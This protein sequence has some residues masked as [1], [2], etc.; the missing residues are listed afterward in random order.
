MSGLIDRTLAE[1]AF[2]VIH[3][4]I[5]SGELGPGDSLRI[6][7]LAE[8]LQISPTPIREALHRL[9]AIGLAEYVPHRG[10]R[11]TDLNLADLQDL[12]EA[13]LVIEPLAVAKAA[14]KF[15]K[16][17]AESARICLAQMALAQKNEDHTEI[18]KAHSE[19]HFTLYRASQSE[20]L[21]KL[22]LPMW[23]R[24]QCYRLKWKAAKE[25]LSRRT[26]E[27]VSILEAC[28]VHNSERASREMYNHLARTAN[29]IAR[30]MGQQE[31]FP[32]RTAR[33]ARAAALRIENAV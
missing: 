4:R 22:I 29:F 32:A 17:Q 13:R 33:G 31:L 2:S 12:Y 1:R 23:E 9:Q 19:F 25:D 28:E 14:E 15:T 18:W 24:S 27:H 16:E 20:W 21:V 5:I 6:E 7:Q 8:T 3:A 10:T 26:A 11:V 30:D